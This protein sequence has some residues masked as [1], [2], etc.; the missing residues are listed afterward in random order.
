M[1]AEV[2]RRTTP[3]V[4]CAPLEFTSTTDTWLAARVDGSDFLTLFVQTAA[5]RTSATR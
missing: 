4:R 3:P 2:N 1:T 5:S